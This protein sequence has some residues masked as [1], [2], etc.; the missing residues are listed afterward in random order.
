LVHVR[1]TELSQGGFTPSPTAFSNQMIYCHETR[2]RRPDGLVEYNE[3][4]L[5]SMLQNE[6]GRVDSYWI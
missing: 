6:K 4:H 5:Y 3:S 2:F 1:R